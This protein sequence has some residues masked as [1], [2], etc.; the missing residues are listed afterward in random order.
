MIT[1]EQITEIGHF[2]Q[3]H[4]IKGEINAV[5]HENVD[6]EALSC[7]I[8]DIDGIYV[9]FFINGIRTRGSRSF[10]ISVDGI[11]SEQKASLL[12]KK[13]IFALT[14]ETIGTAEDNDA[15]GFYA[16]DL[17]GFD[18]ETEDGNFKGIVDDVDDS[19]ENVLFVVK[20]DSGKTH[21]IPVA[22]ELITEID[23]DRHLI[24]VELPDGLLD[25]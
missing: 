12:A 14:G 24:T 2:N 4:G 20:T 8:L 3:P 25:I 16:E 15:C 5:I 21:L 23:T 22:D 18:I 9:P 17:I 7:I 19:T 6:I 10:L 1:I 11:D 13:S